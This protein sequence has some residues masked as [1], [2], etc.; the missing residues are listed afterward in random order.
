M[1]LFFVNFC[2]VSYFILHRYNLIQ[3]EMLLC[4]EHNFKRLIAVCIFLVLEIYPVSANVTVVFQ[5]SL[6]ILIHVEREARISYHHAI[7][8]GGRR[9]GGR[10]GGRGREKKRKIIC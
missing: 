7:E 4:V 8:A 6:K 5:G 9:V 1:V 2:L 10:A 3:T